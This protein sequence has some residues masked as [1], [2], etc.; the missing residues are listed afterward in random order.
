[1]VTEETIKE[2]MK[3]LQGVPFPSINPEIIGWI[4]ALKWVLDPE[5]F[6]LV[7]NVEVKTT[8]LCFR[9]DKR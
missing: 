9:E 5:A 6:H 8:E 7:G 1:M 4:Q 2:M 3:I